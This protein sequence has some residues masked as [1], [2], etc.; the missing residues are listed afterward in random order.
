MV[1]WR[2]KKM[3]PINHNQQNNSLIYVAD[4]SEQKEIKR[5]KQDLPVFYLVNG[6]ISKDNTKSAQVLPTSHW[7]G[8]WHGIIWSNL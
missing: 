3:C 5:H 4:E 6:K 8:R 1:M 2:I 7:F